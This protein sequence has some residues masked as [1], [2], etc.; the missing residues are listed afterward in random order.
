MEI[1]LKKQMKN[2]QKEVILHSVDLDDDIDDFEVDIGS[3]E[4]H[5]RLLA[6]SPHCV[7][8]NLCF[9]ECPVD[10]ISP[11]TIVKRANIED[12]C[13]KCEICAKSC[14]IDCVYVIETKSE[15]NGEEEDIVYSL[16][17]VKVPHR[18]LRLGAI[19][20]DRG[21]C[22]SCNNCTKFCPTKA[23]TLKD[24]SI[25]EAADD[26]EY[27]N[28]EDKK[29]PYI[30]ENICIACGSCVNLCPND[31]ISLE[32]I[33]GPL[34]VT[35]ALNINQDACVQCS[36]CEENCPVE[37]IKVEKDK[38]VLDDSKCI[39]C[40]VCSSKCPVSALTLKS[41]SEDSENINS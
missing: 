15:M 10:A 19:S 31:N 24:K 40:N 25:I 20:I 38:V 34:I 16:K 21:K 26:T 35:K 37:A 18:I 23:I 1:K 22:E 33:L 41:L 27:P 4:A 3:Y 14:P 12:N 29:Y 9:E 17:K 39:K 36:L 11:S 8:C 2:L 6:V 32:R 28:L 13:V 30:E 5:D 7:R